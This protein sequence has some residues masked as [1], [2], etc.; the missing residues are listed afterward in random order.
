MSNLVSFLLWHFT[1][2]PKEI[3]KVWKNFLKLGFFF[4]SAKEILKTLFSPWRKILW[5]K[6]KVFSPYLYFETLIGNL[7]SRLV[8]A[9]IRTGVLLA[10]FGYELFVLFL[11]AFLFF[12]LIFYL[13]VLIVYGISKVK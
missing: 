4:F 3:L 7:I 13:P 9:L 2:Y 5:E 6:P 12:F 10:F 8:G 1:E 11:G